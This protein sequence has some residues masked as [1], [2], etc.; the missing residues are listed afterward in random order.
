MRRWS[1]CHSGSDNSVYGTVDRICFEGNILMMVR[2]KSKPVNV[3]TFANNDE[4]VCGF[5][6]NESVPQQLTNQIYFTKLVFQKVTQ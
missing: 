3:V 1:S 2:I 4:N 6:D 5:N